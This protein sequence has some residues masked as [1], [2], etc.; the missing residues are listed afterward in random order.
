[1]TSNASDVVCTPGAKNEDIAH[2]P[3]QVDGCGAA[4]VGA[5]FEQIFAVIIN[6][7]SVKD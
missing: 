3:P 1:V 4:A 2:E 6:T 5:S 7:R